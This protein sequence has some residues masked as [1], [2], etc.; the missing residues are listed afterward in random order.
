MQKFEELLN[1]EDSMD[2]LGKINKDISDA[3]YNLNECKKKGDYNNMVGYARYLSQS[4][5]K[6]ATICIK[7]NQEKRAQKE[8]TEK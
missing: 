1:E 2:E 8:T 5:G 3:R 6:L 4:Y 7:I